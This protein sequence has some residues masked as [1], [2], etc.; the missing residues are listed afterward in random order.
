MNSR[1]C[2][3]VTRVVRPGVFYDDFVGLLIAKLGVDESAV[4]S[5]VCPGG[6]LN[7]KIFFTQGV[8]C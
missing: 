2:S 3:T 8:W 7:K 5:G 6:S 1:K 4:R